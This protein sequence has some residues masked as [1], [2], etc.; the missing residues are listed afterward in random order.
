MG[1]HF[2]RLLLISLSTQRRAIIR[3][4]STGTA[5]TSGLMITVATVDFGSSVRTSIDTATT[6]GKCDPAFGLGAA[7]ASLDG[8]RTG[9]A[10][11]GD[12]IGTLLAMESTGLVGRPEG[13]ASGHMSI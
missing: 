10:S 4:R 7:P 8:S 5:G 3:S 1:H 6:T 2:N 13:S 9:A 11:E 12:W